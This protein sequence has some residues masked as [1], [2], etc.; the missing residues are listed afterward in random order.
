[1]HVRRLEF[2]IVLATHDTCPVEY[3]KK[4]DE[5]LEFSRTPDPPIGSSGGDSLLVK[6]ARDWNINSNLTDLAPSQSESPRKRPV[7]ISEGNVGKGSFGKVDRVIDVSTGA[8]Y[9][10]KTFFDP[11]KRERE[12]WLDRISREIRIMK[13]HPHVSVTHPNERDG[14]TVVEGLHS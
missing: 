2:R 12:R 1:M 11:G 3:D 14:L 4:V 10:R 5:F 13:D 7:Y 9:A 6:T 8:I